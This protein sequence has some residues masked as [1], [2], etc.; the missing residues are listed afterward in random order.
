LDFD[1]DPFIREKINSMCCK[2]QEALSTNHYWLRQLSITSTFPAQLLFDV[3][4]TRCECKIPLVSS[5]ACTVYGHVLPPTFMSQYIERNVH[6][7]YCCLRGLI[8]VTSA[9]VKTPVYCLLLSNI[10]TRLSEEE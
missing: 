9:Y 8:E 2:V 10:S 1:S 5:G 4:V 7:A 6:T 3:S